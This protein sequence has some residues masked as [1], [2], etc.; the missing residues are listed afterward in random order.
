MATHSKTLIIAGAL[1]AGLAAHLAGQA[2][3]QEMENC[4]GVA[5]AGQNDWA[6]GAGSSCAATPKATIKAILGKWSLRAHAWR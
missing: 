1:V 2:Q 5:L 6:G 4:L 3:A